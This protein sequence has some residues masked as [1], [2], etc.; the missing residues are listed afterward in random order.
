MNIKPFVTELSRIN[1]YHMLAEIISNIKDPALA[2]DPLFVRGLEE[3]SKALFEHCEQIRLLG[4]ILNDALPH[5]N[6]SI[7]R[8]VDVARGK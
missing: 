1:N 3:V 5:S 4:N 7:L 8:L 2:H 6:S